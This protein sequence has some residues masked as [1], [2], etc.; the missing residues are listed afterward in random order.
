MPNKVTISDL[1]K[2]SEQLKCQTCNDACPV[3][4]MS[5]GNDVYRP[6]F[7]AEVMRR[8]FHNYLKPGG[9]FFNKFKHGDIELNWMTI[10]RLLEL[11]YR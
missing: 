3:Y 9:R 1:S 10:S 2:D 5:G 4:E 6:T 8:V 7:R 11:S